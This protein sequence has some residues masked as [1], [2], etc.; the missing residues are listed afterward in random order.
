[1]EKKYCNECEREMDLVL[2]PFA[3]REF[4]YCLICERWDIINRMKK[5]KRSQKLIDEQEE[6]LGELYRTHNVKP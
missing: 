6:K 5:N 3:N 2:D 4:F 1:M